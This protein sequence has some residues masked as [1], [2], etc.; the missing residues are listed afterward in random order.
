MAKE[1]P[2]SATEDPYVQNAHALSGLGKKVK[3]VDAINFSY[4]STTTQYQDPVNGEPQDYHTDLLRLDSKRNW[5]DD[6]ITDAVSFS[7]HIFGKKQSDMLPGSA[8][9]EK[10]KVSEMD[11]MPTDV[12]SY[13]THVEFGKSNMITVNHGSATATSML[14]LPSF[15]G[16]SQWFGDNLQEGTALESIVV[17]GRYTSFSAG[18]IKVGY[19]SIMT[20]DFTIQQKKILATS[21]LRN[22]IVNEQHAKYVL[23]GI[24]SSQADSSE[25]GKGGPLYGDPSNFTGEQVVS[26]LIEMYEEKF[27]PIEPTF[28]KTKKYM[29][30]YFDLP[31]LF[32]KDERDELQNLPSGLIFDVDPTYNFYDTAYENTITSGLEEVFIPNMYLILQGSYKNYPDPGLETVLTLGAAAIDESNFINAS[33]E[34]SDTAI[35]A[36]EYFKKFGENFGASGLAADQPGG[37]SF[38]KEAAKGRNLGFLAKDV[39]ILKDHNEKVNRFPMAA[40]L[41]FSSQSNIELPVILKDTNYDYLVSK[42]AMLANISRQSGGEL[43]GYKQATFIKSGQYMNKSS[44]D[45]SAQL[46][47][48][49]VPRSAQVA[50]FGSLLSSFT[51]VGGSG[52]LYESL[53]QLE[54]NTNLSLAHRF[55]G[56]VP[57]AFKAYSSSENVQGF[58]VSLMEKVTKQKVG[59]LS[60]KKTRSYLDILKGKAAHGEIVLYKIAKHAVIGDSIDP[61]P[62]QQIYL[63]NSNEISEFIYNDTQVVYGKEYKYVIYA[64]TVVFGTEYVALPP[65]SAVSSTSNTKFFKN[66]GGTFEAKAKVMT[67]P[68]VQLI[69]IPY[70]GLEF[71]EPASVFIFDDPPMPP[72]I[73]IGGYRGVN[74][75]ILISLSNNFGSMITEPIA[76]EDGDNDIF[77]KARRYQS[78]SKKLVAQNKIRFQSDDPSAAFQVFRIGPNP[79]TGETKKPSSYSDF[80]GKKIKTVAYP[81]SDSA[82]YV[83]RLQPNVKYYYIFRTIDVHGNIS[84][85][86]VPYEVEMVS[87]PG[88]KLA[89]VIVREASF[90][91]KIKPTYKKSL[92]RFMHIDPRD[93]HKYTTV[94]SLED[95]DA[96]AVN[97]SP[98]PLGIVADP[99]FVK[100]EHAGK[101]RPRK[102]KVRLTSKRSG[103]K[104]DI[105][106]KF[107]HEH[108]KL[109]KA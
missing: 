19:D 63:S 83:D 47:S 57:D 94:T 50:H 101:A 100:K 86:T 30:H 81:G 39:A 6:T 71:D 27:G 31:T 45:A 62:L 22:N 1:N 42:H 104:I 35:A 74:D 90:L 43:L 56:Q 54:T 88:S 66:L 20:G 16:S 108:D 4:D 21:L 41:R 23:Y 72:N 28:D 67:R 76:L 44:E 80:K 51:A 46:K 10:I 40:T 79:V 33:G 78:L 92:K 69:E 15:N 25:G 109:K 85:P 89:Y 106:V 98:P 11:Y 49:V 24:K 75:K 48:Y 60:T 13:V 18:D 95:I 96:E 77:D 97:N 64:Y 82:S 32:D 105:N 53:F 9:T 7:T 5:T 55:V 17:K 103:K 87:E 93:Q 91:D 73:D 12:A 8:P 107:V 102:F 14:D 59:A 34:K 61:S 36:E 37:V 26:Y 99:L 84:N 52:T 29:D 2:G 70:Y 3:Y 58:F 38:I 65:R 68:S